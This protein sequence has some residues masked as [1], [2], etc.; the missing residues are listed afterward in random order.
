MNKQGMDMSNF[1]GALT[2]KVKGCEDV[3]KQ[4]K[5]VLTF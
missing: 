5:V 3:L 2:I 4:P 1:N